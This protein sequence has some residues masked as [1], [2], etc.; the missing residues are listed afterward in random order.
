MQRNDLAEKKKIMIDGE[1]VP[2]LV[3]FGEILMEKGQLEVPEFSFI[4]RIQNGITT[5]PAVEAIYKIQRDT[6]T[7]QFFRDWYFNDESKDITVIRTDASG[8]EFART[9]LPDCEC[10]RY[11][12][13]AFDGSAPVYA[14]VSVT[15]LPWSVIPIS[16]EA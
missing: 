10:V 6:E 11:L 5:I 14:Q 12:E 4:R 13:P 7:L 2:G 8:N 16:A 1:E 3:N 15:L 9:L